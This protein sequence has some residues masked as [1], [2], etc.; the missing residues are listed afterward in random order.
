MI[1]AT[2]QNKHSFCCFENS[3]I[4]YGA[5][6]SYTLSICIKTWGTTIQLLTTSSNSL[7]CHKWPS[8]PRPVF[9]LSISSEIWTHYSQNPKYSQCQ[10]LDSKGCHLG[11]LPSNKYL[12][13]DLKFGKVYIVCVLPWT[14]VSSLSSILS[15]RPLHA[16]FGIHLRCRT[17]G[18]PMASFW[19]LTTQMAGHSAIVPPSHFL[20]LLAPSSSLCRW[21]ATPPLPND[22]ITPHSQPPPLS[23]PSRHHGHHQTPF[24]CVISPFHCSSPVRKSLGNLLSKRHPWHLPKLA[25][26]IL[27]TYL[28]LL[29][30]FKFRSSF[31]MSLIRLRSSCSNIELCVTPFMI[32]SLVVPYPLFS[33]ALVFLGQ[34][35]SQF[36]IISTKRSDFHSIVMN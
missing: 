20:F 22:A 18:T 1:Y 34:W 30:M 32:C 11:Q 12:L 2:L 9:A 27:P 23:T 24:P 36:D 4:I 16:K 25:A 28:L 14:S 8:C 31:S 26:Q 3:Q 5:F 33:S 10:K 19:V 21:P 7:F 35:R 17:A 15:K 13:I 6:L 29:S